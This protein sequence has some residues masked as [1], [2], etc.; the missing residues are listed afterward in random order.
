MVSLFRRLVWLNGRRV[1]EDDGVVLVGFAT[2]EAVEIVEAQSCGP[3]VEWTGDAALPI[4]RVV[5]LAEPRGR[6]AI[7][8]QDRADGCGTARDHIVVAWETGRPLGQEAR[9]AIVVIAPGDQR[10]ARGTADG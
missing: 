2:N 6:I 10:G 1:L 7:V 8:F 5:V 9:T 4:G 3:T